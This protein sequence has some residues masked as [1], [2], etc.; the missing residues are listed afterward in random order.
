MGVY[1]SGNSKNKLHIM[2]LYVT[3]KLHIKILVNT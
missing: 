3:I 1:K 2:K